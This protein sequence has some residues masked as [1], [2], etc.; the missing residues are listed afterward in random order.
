[1]SRERPLSA[2]KLLA[3]LS[4]AAIAAAL[5]VPVAAAT[6]K[7]EAADGPAP[8]APGRTASFLPAGKQGFGTAR[9]RA[10]RVWYTLEGGTL[11][12]VYYPNLSTPSSREL[13][14]VVT[15]GRTFT[16]VEASATSHQVRL[17]DP[18]A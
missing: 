1:M 12:E 2:A 15:D 4:A 16:D 17:A 8:G 14:L 7:L 5:T 3:G 18:R 10:S 9:S 6:A 11:S 13:Q